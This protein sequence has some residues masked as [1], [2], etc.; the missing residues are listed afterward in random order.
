MICLTA[1]GLVIIGRIG[2]ELI[3]NNTAWENYADLLGSQI[4]WSRNAEIWQGNIVSNGKIQNQQ[5]PVRRGFESV[6]IK[7]GLTLPEKQLTLESVA[8]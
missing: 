4:D 7:I 2:H 5:A 3:K 8:A 1:T 6:C